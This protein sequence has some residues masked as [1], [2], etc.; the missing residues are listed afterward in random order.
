MICHK[1]GK[2]DTVT[3][4]TPKFLPVLIRCDEPKPDG[5]VNGNPVRVVPYKAIDLLIEKDG[6]FQRKYGGEVSDVEKWLRGYWEIIDAVRGSKGRKLRDV[7]LGLAVLARKRYLE[8]EIQSDPLLYV[9]KQINR[10][11]DDAEFVLWRHRSDLSAGIFCDGGMPHA[12]YVLMAFR[13]GMGLKGGTGSCVIC[14]TPIDRARG[15]RRKTCSDKCRMRA[16]RIR[17]KALRPGS[18]R[19]GAT[20]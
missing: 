16:S 4:V 8:D 13:I 15:D 18:R 9:S 19:R 17:A 2:Y 14:E 6:A 10:E 7:A 1:V 12:L 5:T 3:T 11:V 20:A